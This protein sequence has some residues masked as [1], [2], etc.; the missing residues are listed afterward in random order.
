MKERLERILRRYK[1]NQ[2]EFAE[3]VGINKSTLSHIFSKNGRGGNLSQSTLEKIVYTFP[4]INMNWLRDGM[5]EM[6]RSNAAMVSQTTIDFNDKQVQEPVKAAIEEPFVNNESAQKAVENEIDN[7]I[8]NEIEHSNIE[9]L[10]QF[11][12]HEFNE[13][14]IRRIVIFYTDNTFTDYLP[15]K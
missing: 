11:P 7:E 5:G 10:N 9:R 6:L 12:L 13:K 15:E 8:D 3:K 14:K 1:L 2:K 4:D